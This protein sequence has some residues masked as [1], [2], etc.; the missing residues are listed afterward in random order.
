[1]PGK[2]Y[3]PQNTKLSFSAVQ[4]ALRFAW[5]SELS[6]EPARDS[7]TLLCAHSALETNRWQRVPNYNLAGIKAAPGQDFAAWTT[8]E[9]ENNEVTIVGH[10]V[11]YPNLDA[12]AKGLIR[13]LAKNPR[14]AKAWASLCANADAWA[15]A[16]ELHEAGYYTAGEHAYGT[17]MSKN[18]DWCMLEALGYDA[19]D[20]QIRAFQAAHPP[21]VVDGAFG[22][23]SR[24]VA[25][26]LLRGV[27]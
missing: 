19:S 26:T 20:V 9:G 1:M 16:H 6:Q 2:E 22:P 3:V 25:K 10:F 21:L 15:Y 23:R 7:L 12:G 27:R 5:L 17:L 24:A 4:D 11:A 13:F 14:Y 18:H 8:H